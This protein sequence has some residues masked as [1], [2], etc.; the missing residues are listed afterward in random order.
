MGVAFIVTGR[1]ADESV[2][3]VPFPEVKLPL[4]VEPLE[5][6]D[7]EACRLE[8]LDEGAIGVEDLV[9]LR[10]GSRPARF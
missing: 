1:A 7:V 9:I 4:F 5:K 2:V 6:T 3:R 10:S 8:Q